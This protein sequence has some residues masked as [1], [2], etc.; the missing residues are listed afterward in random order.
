MDADAP[1]RQALQDAIAVEAIDSATLRITL[2]GPN[3][4]FLQKMALVNVYP[5]PTR[6]Y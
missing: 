2:A 4:T 5:V 6:R 1:A 3:P